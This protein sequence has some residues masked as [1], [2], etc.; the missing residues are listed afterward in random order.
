[1]PL[2]PGRVGRLRVNRSRQSVRDQEQSGRQL[3]KRPPS[4]PKTDRT[5]CNTNTQHRRA[6][7]LVT[8]GS[9]PGQSRH[10]SRGGNI[11]PSPGRVGEVA[12]Q[13]I[14]AKAFGIRNKSG[15][16]L[17]NGRHPTPKRTGPDAIPTH[18]IDGP[19]SSS[20]MGVNSHHYVPPTYQNPPEMGLNTILHLPQTCQT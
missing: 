6:Q 8:H 17:L 3:L 2:P 18:N 11:A 1:M 13:Q 7:K 4:H 20:H 10:T 12:R 16:Q 9:R 19:R 15:R 14:P 5:R